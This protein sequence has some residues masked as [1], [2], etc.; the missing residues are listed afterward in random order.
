MYFKRLLLGLVAGFLCVVGQSVAA[1]SATSDKLSIGVIVPLTGPLAFFGQDYLRTFDLF[2]EDNP[3]FAKRFEVLWE[4]S[5]YDSKQ[6][7][8]AF[9][10]LTTVNK[11]DLIF[12]FGGPMLNALAP[13]AEGRK[14][15][16]FAT[17]SERADCRNRKFCSLFRNEQE[18]WGKA[19]WKMLSKQNHK[20]IAIVKNQN[21]FMNTFV[22]AIISTK[23]TDSTIEIIIDAA[24]D[25][26]DLKTEALVLKERS[27]D[28][29]GVFLLPR[30]H[31]DFIKSLAGM[32]LQ[33]PLFGVEEFMVPEHNRGAESLLDGAAVIAPA[34][35]EAFY[36]RFLQ[37]YGFSAGQF[38]SPAFYDFCKLLDDTLILNADLRGPELVEALRFSGTRVGVSGNYKV[39]RT[40]D[41]VV[42]YSFPIAIYRRKEGTFK[43]DELIEF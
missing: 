19:T 15:P 3:D 31:Q 1:Q 25:A 36:N 24:P 30:A 33:V 38:Y 34:V 2:K 11:A 40:S 32:N 14:V 23:P 10:K 27:Y 18:E 5:A 6:A 16:F 13:L 28:A 39:K 21:Q 35:S 42:S 37:R 20:K 26:S 9:T 29:V 12:T 17:E 4:D 43:I 41:G 22:N 8:A 7:I